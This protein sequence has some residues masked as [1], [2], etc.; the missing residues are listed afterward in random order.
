M[1]ACACIHNRK[2][3]LRGFIK[4]GQIDFNTKQQ[5]EESLSCYNV[6]FELKIQM[7]TLKMQNKGT[8]V[9]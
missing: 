9:G 7:L 5:A 1:Y 8:H 6:S 3:R 4:P 2:T